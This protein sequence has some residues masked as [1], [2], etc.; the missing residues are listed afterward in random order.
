MNVIE[1]LNWRYATKKFSDKKVP[2]EK[3]QTIV[4]AVSLSAS[5]AGMQPYRLLVIENPELRKQ[6]GEGSFNSQ[7]AEASHLLVFAAY[8][9]VTADTIATYIRLVAEQRGLPEVALADSKNR[10]SSTCSA[11]RMKKIL[12]GHPARHISHLA[13]AS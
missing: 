3:L 8:T 7:I 2:A 4:D 1:S 10:W 6:L 13:P 5:S 12:D 11:T 9:S